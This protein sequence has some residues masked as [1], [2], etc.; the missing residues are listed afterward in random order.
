LDGMG[1]TQQPGEVALA[2][3]YATDQADHRNS[4]RSICHAEAGDSEGREAVNC[5]DFEDRTVI[6]PD[7]SCCP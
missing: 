2:R 6:S 4:S 3:S 1:F 7:C 5:K